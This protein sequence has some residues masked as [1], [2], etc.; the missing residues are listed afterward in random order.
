MIKGKRGLA[1]AMSLIAISLTACN[2]E[3][4]YPEANWKDGQ[5][6]TIGGKKYDFDG[7][8]E[9]FE[10]TKNSA[11]AYFS[12]AK[13]VLAQA[14]TKRTD[15]ILSIVDNKIVKLHDTW[16]TNSRSNGTTYKEEQEKTFASENVESE[17]ELR[18][19]YIADQQ[20][21]ENATAFETVKTYDDKS[22]Y[23]I[24]KEATQ[25]Y[26]A[27]NAP[28]HVSHLL[29]KV[30][31]SA[32]G[33][34]FYNG[35]IS[36]EDAKQI[37]NVARLLSSGR[38]FGDAAILASDD[39]SG[40]SY[41]ELYQSKSMIAMQK[42]TSYVN[43]FKLGVYAYDTF[44]NPKTS[45]NATAGENQSTE[46]IRSEL[47]VP[48]TGA[49]FNSK[50]DVA[51]DINNTLYGSKSAFGIPLSA[52]FQMYQIAD[53]EKNPMDGSSITTENNKNI[54][55][56]Q[57]PRNIMFNNYF[58]Y[59]GVSFIYDDSDE[60]DTRFLNELN[61][62]LD[63][64]QKSGKENLHGT[65]IASLKTK[66]AAALAG[67]DINDVIDSLDGSLQY[68]ADEYTYVREQLNGI[69]A[70]R[71]V[72]FNGNLVNYQSTASIN[73]AEQ[74]TTFDK[75][76]SNKKILT[77]ENHNAIII[78]RAGTSSESGYQGIHFIIVNN[79]PFT[80]DSNG[81]FENKYMYYRMNIPSF[82]NTTDAA[83]S[84]KYKEHPS[85]INFVNADANSTT[86]Y[87]NRRDSVEAVIKN[88]LD[89]FDISLW[90]YN[91]NKF[92]TEYGY[93][94]T[95]K[96]SDKV[97]KLIN[98]YITLTKESAATS[99]KDTLDNAWSSYIK[100]LNLQ[101]NLSTNR[102]IPTLG[103]AAFESGVIT[104]EMEEICY[105]A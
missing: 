69:D 83:V 4:T 6:V 54:T 62:V 77:D 13:N 17:E 32:S 24:S 56:R 37:S 42:D 79:D 12:V 18:E 57:Y 76:L 87:N 71:F 84:A 70:S 103:V 75:K 19:K 66:I 91:L 44:L 53:M 46:E 48:G 39:D 43:E 61:N 78:A 29:I 3:Y 22:Q 93:K 67:G 64:M 33:E 27:N 1:L 94:F 98:Q 25:D 35:Q 52:C 65:S 40:K 86:T 95:S 15:G 8:Y 58:N 100:E 88:S 21:S 31:A 50:S 72:D 74:V 51:K 2:Q 36:S 28:Y 55:A 99:D 10:G 96:L 11:Q 85:F 47:R 89:N 63:F 101:V 9:Y 105:V 41:G 7:V 59:R 81:S 26:V 5:I 97:N 90:E 68:K 38:T 16:K 104:A 73:S 49:G 92:E 102:M 23:Y 14:V 80:A 34:G 60:Y 30:D 45:N 20:I 82:T